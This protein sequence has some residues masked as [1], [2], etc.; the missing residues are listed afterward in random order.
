MKILKSCSEEV[1]VSI[2]R[3]NHP[4]LFERME[5][6]GSPYEYF[7]YLFRL[8]H[9]LNGNYDCFVNI[10]DDKLFINNIKEES[11]EGLVKLQNDLI[12]QIIN[13][14]KSISCEVF[15]EYEIYHVDPDGLRM[16]SEDNEITYLRLL[17]ERLEE[18][19]KE[20]KKEI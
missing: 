8:D 13:Y 2:N 12:E 14:A 18:V 4:Y 1:V 10:D 20:L 19:K 7:E 16:I 5:E 3:D 17:I 9:N 6:I 15:D 11:H